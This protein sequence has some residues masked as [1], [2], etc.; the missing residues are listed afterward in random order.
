MPGCFSTWQAG[1][2]HS[3]PRWKCAPVSVRLRSWVS[4]HTNFYTYSLIYCIPPRKS[5]RVCDVNP[6]T[7]LVSLGFCVTMGPAPRFSASSLDLFFDIASRSFPGRHTGRQSTCVDCLRS[8]RRREYHSRS[9]AEFSYGRAP[10]AHT[11]RHAI[12]RGEGGLKLNQGR[13]ARRLATFS[14]GKTLYSDVCENDNV[15][16]T[17][18]YGRTVTGT[19]GRI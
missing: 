19:F 4:H 12:S 5:L 18:T 7:C 3:K 9:A 14:E 15:S 11:P 13:H 2:L 1:S 17:R 10:R 8:L 16:L 6:P